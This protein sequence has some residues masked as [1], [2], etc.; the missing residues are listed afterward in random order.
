VDA[1]QFLGAA[2]GIGGLDIEFVKITPET[3]VDSL[4]PF[5]AAGARLGAKYAIASP[6]DPDLARSADRTTAISDLASRYGLRG[7]LEF[8][9]WTVV[10]DLRR[11]VGRSRGGGSGPNSGS[12]PTRRISTGRMVG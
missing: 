8:F 7:A 2:G 12:W 1:V 5:L 3:E 10:P 4:E 11:R 9:P 6:Y